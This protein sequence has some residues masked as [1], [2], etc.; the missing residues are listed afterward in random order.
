MP[1]HKVSEYHFKDLLKSHGLWH[2]WMDKRWEYERKRK[3]SAADSSSY[4]VVTLLHDENSGY[5]LVELRWYAIEWGSWNNE[6]RV[7]TIGLYV[8]NRE[9]TQVRNVTKLDASGIELKLT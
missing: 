2:D 7:S 3:M 8:V 4:Q 6:R 9:E 5:S 1:E